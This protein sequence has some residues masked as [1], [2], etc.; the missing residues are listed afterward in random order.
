MCNAQILDDWFVREV[1][2][3][4]AVLMRFLRRH[5]RDES[6]IQDLRQEVYSRVYESARKNIP[7][8]A[9]PFVLTAARNLLIDRVRRSRIVSIE[10]IADMDHIHQCADYLT[11]DRHMTARD[12]LKRFQAGLERLPPRCRK[13]VVLRKIQGLSQKEVALHMGIGEDA[14][15]RQTLLGMRALTDF[16]LGG[17]GHIRRIPKRVDKESK[18]P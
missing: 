13:V 17:N 5:W 18:Q 12:E 16:M 14:V 8:Q 2:S 7:M 11:P 1:L 4:E 15:E 3:L 9:Q 10:V 6:D